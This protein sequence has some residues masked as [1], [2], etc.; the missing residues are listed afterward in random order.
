MC[1]PFNSSQSFTTPNLPPNSNFSFI[2]SFL[3]AVAFS[4]KQGGCARAGVILGVQ[5]SDRMHGQE[6]VFGGL[7]MFTFVIWPCILWRFLL[8]LWQFRLG[9]L[10]NQIF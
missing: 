9:F 5:S 2:C 6:G 10:S 7:G 3:F 4:K 1:Y 8:G